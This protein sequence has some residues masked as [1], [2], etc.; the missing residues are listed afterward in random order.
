[1]NDLLECKVCHEASMC[2]VKHLRREVPDD[3]PFE[4]CKVCEQA[5]TT[6]RIERGNQYENLKH[7]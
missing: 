2:D 7:R 5:I 1:M 6:L 3:K 4:L